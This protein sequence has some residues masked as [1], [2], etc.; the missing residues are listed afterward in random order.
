[1]IQA[2]NLMNAPVPFFHYD[3][4]LNE[5]FDHVS[6]LPEGF[7]VVGDE[8][9]AHGVIHE[10]ILLQ[11]FLKHKHTPNQK[12]LIFYRDFFDPIQFVQ[13]EEDLNSVLKK[14][15][16]SVGN[17]IFVINSEQK[18]VGYVAARDVLPQFFGNRNRTQVEGYNKW[19]TDFYFYE[20]FFDKAPFM[21]HSV[22][23]EGRIQMA[24]E[25][26][27][28]VLG[29]EYPEL[30][31]RHLSDLYTSDN[32]LKA[33]TGMQVIFKKGF[34]KVVNSAMR[35]KNGEVIEIE[36][37]S[38]ALLDAQGQAVGTV[39]VSRPIDMNVLIKSLKIN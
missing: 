22:N 2:K 1:M 10:G 16:T 11:I 20:N 32:W 38:R 12:A 14:V 24:N 13:Q 29:Y 35:M 21:M 30:I 17:R 7:A 25:M 36:L 3:M 28:R 31:Q 5:L 8:S 33:Q 4:S 27:H 15:L 18:I 37:A 34:H 6:H 26:L 19:E 39:T 23:S 9:R